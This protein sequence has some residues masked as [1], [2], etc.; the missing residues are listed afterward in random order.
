MPSLA[1]TRDRLDNLRYQANQIYTEATSSGS[2]D[3]STVRCI[4]GTTDE[5]QAK[6]AQLQLEMTDVGAEYDRMR[7]V[8]QEMKA[9]ASAW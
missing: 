2:L 5:K 3:F 8:D 7:R 9:A 4:P 1:E 6:W